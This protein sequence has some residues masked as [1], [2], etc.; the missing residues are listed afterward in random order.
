MFRFTSAL[1]AL[2]LSLS[3]ATAAPAANATAN[4]AMKR[5]PFQINIGKTPN[6]NVAWVAHDN[7]CTRVHVSNLDE[8]PCDGHHF[9]LHG[10]DGFMMAGCGG[11]LYIVQNGNFWAGCR[12]LNE[13]DKCSVHTEWQCN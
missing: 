11:P 9:S 13:K 3:A 8:N 6:E 12:V 7:K 10:E 5:A 4:A 1:L 2:A